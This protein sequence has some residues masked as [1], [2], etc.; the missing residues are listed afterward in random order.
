MHWEM[1]QAHRCTHSFLV[2]ACSHEL[3]KRLGRCFCHWGQVIFFFIIIYLLG[4]AAGRGRSG[5]V[6]VLELNIL[7]WF[8]NS[9]LFLPHLSFNRT[10]VVYSL[11]HFKTNLKY[12][13]VTFSTVLEVNLDWYCKAI[14]LCFLLY[15]LTEWS[16]SCSHG[17][18]ICLCTYYHF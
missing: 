12:E 3:Q 6:L 7:H 16:V 1:R 13:K 9:T 17:K 18:W 8:W 4:S 14:C 15:L 11:L 10:V 2:Y 5:R